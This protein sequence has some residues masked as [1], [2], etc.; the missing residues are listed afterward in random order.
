MHATLTHSQTWERQL[1]NTLNIPTVLQCRNP[2]IPPPRRCYIKQAELVSS[3]Q[4]FQLRV[5]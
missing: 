4:A 2:Y 1:Y 5:Y 3:T